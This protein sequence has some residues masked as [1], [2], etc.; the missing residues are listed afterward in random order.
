[1]NTIHLQGIGE[2]NAKAAGDLKIGEKI[3]WSY[4]IANVV[5]GIEKETAK[6]ITLTLKGADDQ[7]YSRPLKKTRLVGFAA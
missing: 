4:G 7:L 1:M 6:T 2:A 3:L 5:V